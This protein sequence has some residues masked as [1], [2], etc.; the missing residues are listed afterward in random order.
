M[1]LEKLISQTS[2]VV[3]GASYGDEGKGV[4]CRAIADYITNQSNNSI[5]LI[6]HRFNGGSQALHHAFV[7]DEVVGFKMLPSISSVHNNTMICGPELMFDPIIYL[8][9]VEELSYKIPTFKPRLF[10]SSSTTFITYLMLLLI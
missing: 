5:R 2:I 9:N 6:G 8:E 7:N 1:S 3:I 4:V 10:I